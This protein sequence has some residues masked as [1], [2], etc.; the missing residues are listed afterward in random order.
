MGYSTEF[1]GSLRIE[2]ALSKEEFEFLT[3]F[4]ETRRTTR[5]EGPYY[6][7]PK[8]KKNFDRSVG[9]DYDSPNMIDPNEPPDGQPSLWCHWAPSEDG[10][11][12]GW[13]G[14]EKFMGSFQWMQYLVDHFLGDNPKAAS[15]LPF[16]RPHK[17]NGTIR[18]QGDDMNDRWELVAKDNKLT[19]RQ[20][21]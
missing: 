11:E 14:G 12:I 7:A 20:L 10:G 9:Q 2:P 8:S 18:A 4:S 5:K 13:D 6:V 17:L 16:I 1:Q 15:K 19:R 3:R 21:R